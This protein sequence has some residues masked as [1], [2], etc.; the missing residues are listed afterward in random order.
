MIV[1]HMLLS[2]LIALNLKPMNIAYGVGVER[3]EGRS[4][5]CASSAKTLFG[6]KP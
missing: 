2:Q 6:A 5:G 4:E 3:G 1:K